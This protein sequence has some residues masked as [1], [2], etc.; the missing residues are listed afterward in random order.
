[1]QIN[2]TLIDYMG[3]DL[4]VVNAAR[5]S[6]HKESESLE[7]KDEKLI[8]YLAE[9]KHWTPFGHCMASFR[10]QAPIFV[11]RQLF[12][13]QVGLVV[14]EVSR[15]YVDDPPEFFLPNTWR[16]KPKNAKQGSSD[17]VLTCFDT[18]TSKSNISAVVKSLYE[19]CEEVYNL[20]IDSGVAPEQAR[21]MLPQAMSTEWIWTGSL[22]AWARVCNLRLDPHAQ[23][24]TREIAKQVSNSMGTLFPVSWPVLM[25]NR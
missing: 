12:K 3:T 25:E 4:T 21:M 8:K 23:E 7:P 1:M 17:E 2:A 15:R 20:M 11:A 5:V 10:I 22:A 13:H 9:H 19:E 6:F 18:P 24:E 16:G 14:N